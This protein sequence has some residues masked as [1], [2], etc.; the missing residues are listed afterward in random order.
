MKEVFNLNLLDKKYGFW[1]ATKQ[2][3]KYLT[4]KMKKGTLFHGR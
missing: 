4:L 3:K 1:R 2:P